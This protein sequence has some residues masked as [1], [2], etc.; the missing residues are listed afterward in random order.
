MALRIPKMKV[1]SDVIIAMLKI[2]IKVTGL[3][4][5][6]SQI[7]QLPKIIIQRL[8]EEL[9]GK[10][11]ENHEPLYCEW[12]LEIDQ[13]RSEIPNNTLSNLEM[14]SSWL[15]CM[16]GY[17]VSSGFHISLCDSGISSNLIYPNYWTSDTVLYSVFRTKRSTHQCLEG[18]HILR[19]A[20][21]AIVQVCW[22]SWQ[23]QQSQQSRS[24][25]SCLRTAF[26]FL[27]SHNVLFRGDSRRCLELADL[28]TLE[29]KNE[30]PT[31]CCPLI[32]IKD[33]G[34]TNQN[35]R[36]EYSGVVRHHNPLLCTVSHLSFY[37]FYRWS[38]AGEPVPQFQM[39]QQ[40]YDMYLIKGASVVKRISYDTLLEWTN[41]V[42]DVAGCTSLKKTHAGRA[43]GARHAE[44]AGTYLRTKQ[45]IYRTT[46]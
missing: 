37:L 27:L 45:L 5:P 24:V 12:R 8:V 23:D 4:M 25:E 16:A 39:R 1:Q 38:V 20:H 22:Q 13:G 29:L 2:Y 28:F 35:G 15:H 33:N 46:Y 26:D 42:F 43:N 36:V 31:R 41:R 34:K 40:W 30:G 21:Q 14:V 7:E 6:R 17:H 32:L 44:L 9:F 19:R 3:P 10:Y 18:G 11:K